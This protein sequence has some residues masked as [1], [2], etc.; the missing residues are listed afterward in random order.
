MHK[1]KQ[2]EP[3][4]LSRYIPIL[5]KASVG[6]VVLKTQC[7]YVLEFNISDCIKLVVKAW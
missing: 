5:F 3:G 7:F 4:V 2:M 6:L 1:L